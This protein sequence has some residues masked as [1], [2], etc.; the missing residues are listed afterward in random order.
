[1]TTRQRTPTTSDGALVRLAVSGDA[2]AEGIPPVPAGVDVTVTFTD[3]EAALVHG[4]AL[5][6]LGYRV[7]GVAPHAAAAGPAA[8]LLI[9]QAALEAHPRW[10]RALADQAERAYSLLLGPAAASLAE[11]LR[12]HR[13]P[14]REMV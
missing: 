14:V 9:P 7:V 4:D 12:A 2:W 3:A 11:V 8:D 1:M 10:W 5:G 6:L 13:E